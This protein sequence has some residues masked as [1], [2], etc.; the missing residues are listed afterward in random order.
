MRQTYL[1]IGSTVD[2]L[3]QEVLVEIV[4][5]MLVAKPTGRTA[6]SHVAPVVV[7][8]CDVEVAEVEIAE[9]SVVANEGRLPVIVE[10][11]P[12]DGDPV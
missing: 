6:S 5:N 1:V 7:M 9:G 12:G 4:V 11:V 2:S 3:V 8:I 10:V